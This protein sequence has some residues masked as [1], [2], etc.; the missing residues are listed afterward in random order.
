[1]RDVSGEP[2]AAPVSERERIVELDVLR[3]L[4]LFGVL[5]VNFNGFAAPGFGITDAQAAALPTARLDTVT[6][7]VLRLLMSD[8]ANTVFATLF[9]LG[10]YIQMTRGEGRPGFA[11]RYRRRLFW[12]LAFGVANVYLLWIWDILHL[13]A[14]AGF[15]LL[16]M[17][18]WS[19]RALAGFGIVA[20]LYSDKLHQW[21]IERA[22][23]SLPSSG[24][25]TSDAGLAER[26]AVMNGGDYG[27]IFDHWAAF[28]WYDWIGSTVMLAA[29][30]YAL[31]R[32]A[33]GAAIGRSGLFDDIPRYLPLLRRIAWAGIPAGLVVGALVRLT[34]AGAF[35]E[36]ADLRALGQILR[37][38]AALLLAAG[39]CAGVIV[40]LQAAW[41]RRLFGPFALVGQMA[42]TNYLA[43]GLLYAFV[44]T[45]FG[46]GLALDGKIGAF[47]VLLLSVG[48]FACQMVCSAGGWRATGS[49]RWNGCGAG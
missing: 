49:D 23:F 45:G 39:Y 16:A 27:A 11:A 20:A 30:I 33:I 31:G 10:F 2:L 22:G 19:T 44:L 37:S 6:S 15:L 35:G 14:L 8:K 47:A 17:R 3:G 43:Q 25:F 34:Y 46:P 42:L 18:R 48:F 32:F 36:D 26:N 1:M 24:A 13:Y 28:N 38:P 29:L 4:A 21:L 9:G 40:A 5:A 7:W 12:L 41:G